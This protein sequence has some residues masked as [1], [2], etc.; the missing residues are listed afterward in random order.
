MKRFF[1][2]LISL[3]LIFLFGCTKTPSNNEITTGAIATDTTIASGQTVDER[4]S[5]EN[6]SDGF[7]L[8]FPKTRTF[9]EK[10]FQSAVMFFSP[11]GSWDKIREN[12]GVVKKALDKVYTLDEYYSLT[13]PGLIKLIPGFT[14]VSN[15]A[16]KVNDIDGQKLI[17]TWVQWTTQLKRE[18]VY[19]IKDKAVYIVTYTAPESSFDEFIQKVDEMVATLEIK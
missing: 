6:K 11:L 17:Y 1:S 14:E 9:Q 8:Q 3:G 7:S 5:Y 2:L 15:T 18:Q 10:A 12:V 19:L 4:Q 13:K 16:I